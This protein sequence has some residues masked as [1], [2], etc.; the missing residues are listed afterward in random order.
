MITAT[1]VKISGDKSM[2]I[3]N[4]NRNANTR[5]TNMEGLIEVFYCSSLSCG[6]ESI[7]LNCKNVAT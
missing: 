3:D 4:N 7:S 5:I 6:H 2:N 1:T